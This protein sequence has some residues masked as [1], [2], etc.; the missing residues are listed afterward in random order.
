[1]MDRSFNKYIFLSIVLIATLLTDLKAQETLPINLEKVLELGGANNLTIKKLE[2]KKQLAKNNLTKSKEWWLPEIYAGVKTHNLRGSVMNGN[3]NF[4]LDVNRNNLWAGLGL[5]ASWDFSSGIYQNKVAAF[6]TK[7][8]GYKTET[9]RNKSILLIVDTYYDFVTAQLGFQAYQ[10]LANQS[11]SISAQLQ[12]QVESGLAYQ[13]ELLLAKSNTNHLKVEMLNKKIEYRKASAQL[14]KLLNLDPTLKL[15]GVDTLMVPLIDFSNESELNFESA[16]ENR[17]ELKEADALIEG[18]E[19]EKKTATTGLL[20]PELRLNTYASGFGSMSG[21][22]SPMD[23]LSY[24]QTNQVYPTSALNVSLM[25]KVP[26]GSLIYAGDVKQHRSRIQIQEMSREQTKA[27]INEEILSTTSTIETTS[28]QMKIASEGSELAKEALSQCIH[29]QK[30]GT[31]RPFEILQA[32]EVFIKSKLDYFKSI[33]E[34]NK[35]QFQLKVAKG[36]SL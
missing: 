10:L 7:A 8:I 12:I 34:F 4:F 28:E 11:D 1:M 26:L 31:V 16:Y 19:M 13:S 20:F 24:P 5:D 3:G 6:K 33:S 18:L 30:M 36:E 9:E 35:A 14:V 22:V 32:Q 21:N 27:S 29:R 23:R 2:L 15:V 17:S 25:W